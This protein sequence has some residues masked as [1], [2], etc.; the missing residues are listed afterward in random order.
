[1]SNETEYLVTFHRHGNTVPVRVYA[2][3]SST[4]RKL[5]EAQRPEGY[6]FG[7]IRALS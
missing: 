6:S 5:A 3:S 1:M 7:G 2:Q 4:A